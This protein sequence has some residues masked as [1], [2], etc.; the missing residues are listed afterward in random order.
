MRY[1]NQ[2]LFVSFDGKVYPVDVSGPEITFGAPWPLLT[3][4]DRAEWRIGGLQHLA[5]HQRTGRLYSLMHRGGADTHKESGEEI[6]IYD[7]QSQQRVRAHQARQPGADDLRISRR[8]RAHVALAVQ[9]HLRLAARHVRPGGDQLHPGDA[10]R[11]AVAVHRLAVQRLARRVRRGRA[12]RS[13]AVSADGMDERRHARAVG[14]KGTAM[15]ARGVGSGSAPHAARGAGAAV[16][17]GGESQAARPCGF[18]AALAE[19]R[20]AC[21]SAGCARC[22][23]CLSRA[24]LAVGAWPLRSRRWLRPPACA[25]AALLALYAG[26]IA[27]NLIRGRRDI[28]CGCAGA[29]R[30]SA[31]Q[32]RA[33]CPQRR[34]RRGALASALPAAARVAHVDR[35]HH[36]R[37]GGSDAGAALRGCR[38][39]A[40]ERAADRASGAER[41]VTS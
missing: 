39:S 24:E 10:G 23:R 3:D 33:R 18:R 26:A 13:C 38:W 30:R 28:D 19:L 31:A 7:L 17:L 25:A 35:L 15:T 2:W 6:W 22:P 41:P 21:R 1:G 4:A 9:S 11:C 34:A 29:A 12:A 37:C 14:R 8:V 27:I 5:V 40:R 16:R 20:A 32:R 36:D